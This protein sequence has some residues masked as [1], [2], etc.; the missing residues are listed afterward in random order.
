MNFPDSPPSACENILPSATH[1]DSNE[2]VPYVDGHLVKI[3]VND[4]TRTE[5]VQVIIV[6]LIQ[7]GLTASAQL[8][9]EEA[10]AQLRNNHYERKTVRALCRSVD[11]RNWDSAQ[12]NMKK[13]QN[14]VQSGGIFQA[15]HPSQL[16]HLIKTLPFLL[17]QQQY[18]ELV[19]EDD[20]QRSLSFFIRN[21]KPFEP[22]ISR[23]HFKKLS[24]L[25]SCKT[26]SESANIYPEY[27]GWRPEIGR[28]QLQQFIM[29]T[30][31]SATMMP[32]LRQG[33]LVTNRDDNSIK[34]LQVMLAQSLS[35]DLFRKQYPHL[36]KGHPNIITSTLRVSF[37]NHLPPNELLM[38]IDVNALLK[39]Y[40]PDILPRSAMHCLGACR[41]FLTCSALAVSVETKRGGAVFWVSLDHLEGGRT[42]RAPL[43][44]QPFPVFPKPELTSTPPAHGGSP[45]GEGGIAFIYQHPHLIRGM[46]GRDGNRLLVWGGCRVAVINLEHYVGQTVKEALSAT[47]TAHGGEAN[48]LHQSLSPQASVE[49]MLLHDAE[50]YASCFFTCGTIVATGQSDGT[51]TLWDTLSGGKMRESSYGYGTIVAILSSR[52]GTTY[53][54]ACKD[55]PILVVDVA[56]GVLI[57]TL[58]SPILKEL[59]DIALSPSSTLLLASY[60]G[61]ELRLWDII[62]SQLLP[63]SFN[64]IENNSRTCQPV[65]FW[66]SDEYLFSASDNGCLYMW[67][68]Q[69]NDDLT[70][71]RPNRTSGSIVPLPKRAYPLASDAFPTTENKHAMD[72]GTLF[73]N[74]LCC[75]PR[76]SK[77]LV[78]RPSQKHFLH[79][80][81]ITDIETEGP[82]L[83]CSSEDGKISILS[84]SIK[85]TC[86]T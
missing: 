17:S 5:I 31:D 83:V 26:V 59:T 49:N 12:K 23:E 28:S 9:R 56:T 45:T 78:K 82:Y 10:T 85:S 57:N 3:A 33:N 6:W 86:K 81:C 1:L 47:T 43:M 84:N 38:Q 16:N 79:H 24:Y 69:N 52:T 39:Q 15:E 60:R 40:F 68:F 42:K 4:T 11:E 14:G 62:S 34:P 61:G 53:Y 64:G 77:G 35:F 25:L 55:G 37:D 27:R 22:L 30:M 29:R 19:D 51:V 21:I 50:V 67:N 7:Q 75:T 13:L 18:L 72:P 54:A 32:Y 20:A 71:V 70:L 80:A 63:F 74:S 41:T 58:L 46:C 44:D 2:K 8:L 65:A 48:L 76:L 36:Q 66:N 73:S